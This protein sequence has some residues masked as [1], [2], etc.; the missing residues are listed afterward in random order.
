MRPSY[1]VLSASGE[2]LFV[3]PDAAEAVMAAEDMGLQPD[4]TD[5]PPAAFEQ[6]GNPIPASELLHERGSIRK[7]LDESGV[8]QVT[9]E[10]VVELTE[11]LSNPEPAFEMIRHLF[12]HLRDDKGRVPSTVSDPYKFVG[13]I[14]GGNQKM[15]KALAGFEGTIK[16]LA[17]TPYWLGQYAIEHGMDR[18]GNA[19]VNVSEKVP[20]GKYENP[21][22]GNFCTGSSE[23]CRAGCLV[24]TGRNVAQYAMLRKFAM[25][26]A[27][28]EQP[29]AFC[30][31]LAMA[32]DKFARKELK[33]GRV[34]L[35][36]LNVLSDIPWEVAF[37]G[38]FELFPGFEQFG[39]TKYAPFR[40]SQRALEG[41][42]QAAREGPHMPVSVLFYDYSKNSPRSRRLPMHYDI[43]FSF[44]GENAPEAKRCLETGTRVAVVMM[45]GPRA[46]KLGAVKQRLGQPRTDEDSKKVV[47]TAPHEIPRTFW[48]RP[49]INGDISDFRAMDKGGI[50]VAL[51]YKQ[52]KKMSK[53]RL[54]LIEK[55]S[56]FLVQVF[57]DEESGLWIAAQLPRESHAEVLEQPVE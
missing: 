2:P 33:Q 27:L 9:L 20:Y 14:L 8:P 55:E 46:H 13:S 54:S 53:A 44:N 37:P 23:A 39:P 28:L 38:L 31:L 45:P 25:T 42:F 32:V 34:P 41:A 11:G 26:R 57:P 21:G 4:V 36:R 30:A 6:R 35:V 48:G 47:F 19:L 50:V 56:A 43:T 29:V 5:V 7:V 15:N 17:L 22:L 3:T 51:I 49:V 24:M 16:G 12:A 18:S 10:E 52:P 40:P 1:M